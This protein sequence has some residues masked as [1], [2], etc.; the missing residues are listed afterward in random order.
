MG[1]IL[2]QE[3]EA[4]K[5]KSKKKNAHRQNQ[6]DL[7]EILTLEKALRAQVQELEASLAPK[8]TNPQPARPGAKQPPAPFPAALGRHLLSRLT[9]LEAATDR[10]A[11]HAEKQGDYKTALRAV[12]VSVRIINTT[13][14]V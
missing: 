6:V 11:A 5:K 10:L 1:G 7:N 13:F 8:T 2:G 9:A 14:S 4:M 12:Q 3:E